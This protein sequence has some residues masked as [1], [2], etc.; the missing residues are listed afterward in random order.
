[1]GVGETVAKDIQHLGD[2]TP[3]SHNARR[4]N[5]RNVGMIERALNEVGAARSIVVDENGVVLAGNATI[6]AAAAAGIERV[7]VVD[8]DGETII[9]VRRT[10]LT[11][12]QKR[13]LALFD[14]RTAELADWDASSILAD[15]DAGLD[16]SAL[17]NEGEIEAIAREV[18]Q[19]IDSGY[20]DSEPPETALDRAEAL[21][22]QYGVARGQLWTI[23]SKDGRRTHRLLCGDTNNTDDVTRLTNGAKPDMLHTDPPYGIGIV[24]PKGLA[25]TGQVGGSKPFGATS[26]TTR[27][28]SSVEAAA[29][30]RSSLNVGSVQRGPKSPNQIIQSNVYP[31]IEG[32]D[33]PF[34]PSPLLNLA[35]I[36]ILWGANYYTDKLPISSSWLCWDKREGITRNS[37]ADCELAWCS[38]G[39]TARVFHHLWNGLHKG[40]QHGERRTHPTEKPVAL[41]EEVGKM[42]ADGGLWVDLYAG[43]GAQVIAAERAGATCYACEI[44]PRYVACILDRLSRMGLS[45]RLVSI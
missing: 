1:M 13:K 34:D 11:D 17:W 24:S 29:G 23:Q 40:S 18:G 7:Q 26:G 42:Y 4:H 8:A 9:A 33:K 21:V 43:T 19:G 15:L 45:P 27:K 30:L 20:G 22:E 12:E 44:E 25:A 38:K 28:S 37:F 10:G 39:G 6:E 14:N 41:F 32:D 16:L 36:V 3:D 31:V 2:L 35:P 5:P